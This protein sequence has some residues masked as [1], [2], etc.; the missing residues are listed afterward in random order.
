MEPFQVTVHSSV[1]AFPGIIARQGEQCL[2]C[3][4]FY[5][6]IHGGAIDAGIDVLAPMGLTIQIITIRECQLHPAALV[7]MTDRV[8]MLPS[9]RGGVWILLAHAKTRFI[10]H[11]A[12]QDIERDN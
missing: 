11:K 12:S 8:S 7:H 6:G 4:T 9:M 2:L 1:A 10:A 5:P 3:Q